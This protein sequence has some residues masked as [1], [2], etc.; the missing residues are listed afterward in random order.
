MPRRMVWV[1]FASGRDCQGVWCGWGA[2][3]GG[4]SGRVGVGGMRPDGVGRVCLCLSVLE[5]VEVEET[6]F[7]LELLLGVKWYRLHCFGVVGINPHVV[8]GE[9]V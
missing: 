6:V 2:P 3:P 9:I 8:V 7:D 1:G 5:R 4:M